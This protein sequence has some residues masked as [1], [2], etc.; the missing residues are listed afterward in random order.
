LRRFGGCIGL[1]VLGGDQLSGGH[2]RPPL[3]VRRTEEPHHVTR[4]SPIHF[5][6]NGFDNILVFFENFINAAPGSTLYEDGV[7]GQPVGKFQYD[8]LNGDLP[9][10]TWLCAPEI[11]DEHPAF[12]PANGGG[13]ETAGNPRE[14]VS[15]V[16]G[17]AGNL[18]TWEQMNL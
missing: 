11:Y 2:W 12:W 18:A 10:V 13:S 3:R 8:C 9:T 17:N 15:M 16:S 7:I 1:T 4:H 14:E 5:A 6:L